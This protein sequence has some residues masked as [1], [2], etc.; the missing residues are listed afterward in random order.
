MSAVEFGILT[1]VFLL[2]LMGS[3]DMA[4]S[5][6]VRSVTLGAVETLT[7]AI[8]VEGVDESAAESQL[9]SN[10]LTVS[11]AADIQVQRGS[12]SRFGQMGAMEPITVD[13]T[14][15]G[16]L[17]IGDCWL[18]IDEDNNRNVV[19]LGKN[20]IGGADDVVRYDVSAKFDRLFPIWSLF[21]QP[22]QTTVAVS[23]MV[24]RQPFEGQKSPPERCK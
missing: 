23:T 12:V 2:L 22:S 7:R 17:D 21:N 13:R 1:P 18:D 20:S 16:A 11:P 15:N 5:V 3:F 6:Y 9:R 24:R 14:S 19:T 4:Y 10:I 8:T